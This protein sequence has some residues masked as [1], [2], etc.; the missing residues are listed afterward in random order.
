MT[1][2][3]AERLHRHGRRPVVHFYV[4]QDHLPGSDAEN[5]HHEHLIGFYERNLG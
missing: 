2:R 5:E 3:L 1:Q 4:G